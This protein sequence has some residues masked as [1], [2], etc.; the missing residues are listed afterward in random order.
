VVE[1]VGLSKKFTDNSVAVERVMGLL[2]ESQT[3]FKVKEPKSET[4]SHY[5][6]TI[7]T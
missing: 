2:L 6:Y 1:G 5:S 4:V 7:S 3:M